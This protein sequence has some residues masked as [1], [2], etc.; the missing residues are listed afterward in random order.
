LHW[1]HDR[2]YSRIH[3][4]LTKHRPHTK[5][6]ALA[7]RA[8][9]PTPTPTP[10]PTHTH[11]HCDCLAAAVQLPWPQKRHRCGRR[12]S[13]RIQSDAFPVVCVNPTSLDAHSST[14]CIIRAPPPSHPLACRHLGRQ[15]TS[16][17]DGVVWYLRILSDFIHFRVG[18][19][20]GV[21]VTVPLSKFRWTL[22]SANCL[23]RRYLARATQAS[24][25]SEFRIPNSIGAPLA[26]HSRPLTPTHA[27]SRPL[28]HTH[29]HTRT[30]F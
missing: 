14:Y 19:L 16:V 23:A 29:T 9:A 7:Y 21:Y 17:L 15:L 6:S 18:R 11:T 10:T 28:T 3:N 13:L 30:W 26:Q 25:N 5:T 24:A 8:T 22:E 12:Y 1:T 27:H 4:T 2:G 20:V